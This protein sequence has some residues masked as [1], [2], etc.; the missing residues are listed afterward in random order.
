[1]SL[2]ERSEL[3]R[4]ER[5]SNRQLSVPITTP[6]L[7]LR[8]FVDSDVEGIVRLL[9]NPQATQ[10]IGGPLS[11]QDAAKSFTRM[12]QAFRERG[13][14]TL[15]VVPT[16]GACC[17]G[18]C[19]VRPLVQTT[20][21][22]IAFALDPGCWN[23]GYATEAASACIDS[24]FLTLGLGSIVGTVYPENAASCRVLAKL[25]LTPRGRVFGNWPNNY[26]LLFR[27]ERTTWDAGRN[28]GGGPADSA[29]NAK[30]QDF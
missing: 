8:P 16:G 12:A 13:W 10:F 1:M 15:A 19:G 24:A 2:D 20:D 9:T 14:G 22:E 23:M 5:A 18:Y 4:I 3:D 7:E 27:V 30:S 11:A 29:G 17:I 21:V 26:A 6:R 25:G 28:A